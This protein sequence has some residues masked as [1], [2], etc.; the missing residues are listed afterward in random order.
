MLQALGNLEMP[1]E[2][3]RS[4]QKG[5]KFYELDSQGVLVRH[6]DVK[7]LPNGSIIFIYHERF[8]EE[9]L[10]EVFKMAK[11]ENFL[12]VFAYNGVETVLGLE[13]LIKSDSF[14]KELKNLSG[15]DPWEIIYSLET[16]LQKRK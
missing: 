11:R 2:V 13:H 5:L 15:R 10:I 3:L 14:R 1:L 9:E 16:A 4:L 12:P 6:P 8:L 7:N